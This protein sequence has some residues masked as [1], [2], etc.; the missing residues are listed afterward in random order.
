MHR[1]LALAALATLAGTT[2]ADEARRGTP[3]V[4]VILAD[5]EDLSGC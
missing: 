4:I 1:L 5:D 3:N 2:A